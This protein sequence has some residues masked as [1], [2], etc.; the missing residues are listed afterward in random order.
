MRTIDE[1]IDNLYNTWRATGLT[2]RELAR[3]AKLHANTL[4]NFGKPD[5]NP[6][7]TTLRSLEVALGVTRLKKPSS[8]KSTS[9]CGTVPHRPA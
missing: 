3:R 9:P 5:F 8:P 7:P 1:L 2:Q 4:R 6:K